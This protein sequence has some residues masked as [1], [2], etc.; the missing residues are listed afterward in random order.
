[1][2]RQQCRH[3]VFSWAVI[4]CI[5][6]ASLASAQTT[7]TIVGQVIDPA[8][9]SVAGAEVEAVNIDTGLSRQ[10]A[11]NS[12]GTYLIPSLPPG[13]YKVTVKAPGF[14]AFSQTGVKV[15]VGQ[16]PRVDVHLEVGAVTENVTVEANTVAVD[17]QSSQVG[18]TIDNQRLVNLPLNGRNILQL[19][20]FLPGVA[21]VSFPT[22]VTTSRGGPTV[23]VSG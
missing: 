8:N 5:A 22:V 1:M 10:G 2:P 6:F 13:N 15:E 7:G 21:P 20:T 12:E 3:F 4:A 14:K 16:N 18:A 9:A 23:S 19:A 11:T 17:T